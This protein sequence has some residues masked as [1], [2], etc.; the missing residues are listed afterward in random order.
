MGVAEMVASLRTEHGGAALA[1][2]CRKVWIDLDN[3]P[4]VPFF[5]PII[6]ELELRGFSTVLTA[7]SAFQ[8]CDLADLFHLRYTRIG[9]HYGKHKALKAVGLGVRGLQLL[10]FALRERPD[11]AL[12]HGS[13]PQ[14]VVARALGIPSVL[15]LDYEFARALFAPT[16]TMVPEM[17]PDSAVRFPKER[18]LRYPGIK[19]DVYA[20]RF[21]PDPRIRTELGLDDNHVVVTVRPPADEAHYHNRESEKLF[22]AVMD[23]LAAHSEAKIILLP[24][25]GRQAGWLRRTWSELFSDGKCV[26]PGRAHDGL[27]LIWYSDLVVSGGGTMNREAAALG[28]PVYSIFRGQIGAVDRYLAARGRLVL[29]TSVEDV[30]NR[31]VLNRRARAATPEAHK[32]GPLQKIV[33]D[34]VRLMQPPATVVQPQ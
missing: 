2:K 17:I 29:L 28:V 10:P 31:I 26:I 6:E 3:T 4:H 16:W 8:V 30:R 19:E 7:R 13:R 27:N 18:L 20:P 14:L 15:I 12:S 25:N 33:D 11:L 24:R 23:L 34:L 21:R 32:D 9:H 5:A 22:T 1:A